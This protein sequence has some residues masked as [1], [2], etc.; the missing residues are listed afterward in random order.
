MSSV[1]R[2][3][4][5]FN[6]NIEREYITW[7]PTRGKT[8]WYSNSIVYVNGAL[9]LCGKTLQIT[10]TCFHSVPYKSTSWLQS[11]LTRL[12]E[13]KIVQEG[14]KALEM[15]DGKQTPRLMLLV[16]ANTLQINKTYKQKSKDDIP[17]VTIETKTNKF[18]HFYITKEVYRH[19][20]L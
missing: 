16:D 9:R 15:G 14:G 7:I 13:L 19:K 6:N 3:H 11:D 10:F 5:S 20:Y 1:R 17:C 8:H 2:T 12:G 4:K 18:Y